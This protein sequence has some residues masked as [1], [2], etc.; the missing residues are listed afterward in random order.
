M[1]ETSHLRNA[2]YESMRSI[3]YTDE[4]IQKDWEQFCKEYEEYVAMVDKL[5]GNYRPFGSSVQAAHIRSMEDAEKEFS[6]RLP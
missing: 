6:W 2:H 4:E 5:E 1:Q 3:G